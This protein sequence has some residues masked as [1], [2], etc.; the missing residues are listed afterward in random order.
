M[1]DVE[2]RLLEGRLQEFKTTIDKIR[3]YR[4]LG[5]SAFPSKQGEGQRLYHGLVSLC[6]AEPTLIAE[7]LWRECNSNH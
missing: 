4:A 5:E 6:W 1:T 3:T 7:Y 2:A